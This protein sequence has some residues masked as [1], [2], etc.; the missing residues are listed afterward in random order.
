M[1]SSFLA[2]FVKMKLPTVS[3]QTEALPSMGFPNELCVTAWHSL[4]ELSKI[5]SWS[6]QEGGRSRHN[7]DRHAAS[8]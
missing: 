5:L 3:W 8:E 6:R 1:V 4:A 2:L 7:D